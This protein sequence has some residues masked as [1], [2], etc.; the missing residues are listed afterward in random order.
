MAAKPARAV[1]NTSPEPVSNIAVSSGEDIATVGL[2][3]VAYEY[4]I[5]VGV[6]ALMLLALVVWLL[7]WARRV[8][9]R[10]FFRVPKVEG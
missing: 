8:I 10:L 5:A 6:I 2:L 4:P 7:M 1:V 9:K 3:W